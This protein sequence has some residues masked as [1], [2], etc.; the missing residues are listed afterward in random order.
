M[1]I[2]DLL[3]ELESGHPDTGAY[4]SDDDEAVK[5]LHA[6]NRPGGVGLGDVWQTI[7]NML[8][9]NSVPVWEAIEAG[10]SDEEGFGVA[11]R[12]AIRVRGARA[13][14]PPV[15]TRS[16]VFSAQIDALVTGGALSEAQGNE[17]KGL[18]DNLQSRASELGLGRVK[19]V[20]VKEARNG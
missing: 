13:D 14:Y 16:P 18:S 17:I 2:A 10:Q 3:A 8:D 6:L 12:A 20:H 4:S 11:C 1:N 9:A 19:G 15:N 5:E 7:D